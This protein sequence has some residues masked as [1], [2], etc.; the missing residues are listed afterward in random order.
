[1]HLCRRLGTDLG[2][3]GL[4]VQ[5]QGLVLVLVPLLAFLLPLE[6]AVRYRS[7][8]AVASQ[9]PR[10]KLQDLYLATSWILS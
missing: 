1:M 8:D 5:K 4:L 7:L 2:G 3:M 6:V 9:G 10:P